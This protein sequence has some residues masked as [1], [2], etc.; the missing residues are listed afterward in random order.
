MPF[1]S[2]TR[3]A[4]IHHNNHFQH[5]AHVSE[6]F[7]LSLSLIDHDFMFILH[8]RSPSHA[9]DLCL[10]LILQAEEV[11]CSHS[12]LAPHS[13]LDR[14]LSLAVAIGNLPA[15]PLVVVTF[16]SSSNSATKLIN[17]DFGRSFAQVQALLRVVIK[18]LLLI[19]LYRRVHT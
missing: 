17:N 18:A 13:G 4:L 6:I 3:T 14:N 8:F 15:G 9:V 2:L 7:N 19:L 1:I 5:I 16:E 12:F 10:T 11:T